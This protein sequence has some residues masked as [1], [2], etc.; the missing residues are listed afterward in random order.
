[1]PEIVKLVVADDHPIVRK[2]LHSIVAEHPDMDIVAEASRGD[3]LL[4][5]LQEVDADVLL[6]DITMPGPSFLDILQW[7]KAK[8]PTLA[9]LILSAHSEEQYAVRAL[10]AGAAGYLSKEHSPAQL[11]EAVRRIHGGGRYVSPSLAERLLQVL[12]V[13][14]DVAPHERL[15]NREYRVLCLLGSGKSVKETSAELAVSP[16]TVSTYRARVLKKLELET[17]ADLI[18]Y[19]VERGLT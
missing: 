10:K 6:L 18:R 13:A 15:S 14:H 12:D 4:H 5:L 19:V 2:G 7:V 11:A 16:K 9:V 1:M 8:R 3:E 17:T